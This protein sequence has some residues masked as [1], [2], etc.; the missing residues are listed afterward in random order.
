MTLRRLR[1]VAILLPAACVL[2]VELIL[3]RL[4]EPSLG[5]AIAHVIGAAILIAG[6][7]AFSLATFGQIESKEQTILDLYSQAQLSA[8][9]LER[10]IESSGDAIIT[11]NLEGQILSWSRGA[12]PFL[13]A[14]LGLS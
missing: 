11:V 1:W 8:A 10:L 7:V 12:L 6:I 4:L 9:R 5:E 2:A 14:A 3:Y 13:L